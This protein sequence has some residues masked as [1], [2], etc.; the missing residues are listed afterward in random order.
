M[1]R[2]VSVFGVAIREHNDRYGL[3]RR[4]PRHGG[5]IDF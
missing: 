1:I 5:V 4:V 3:K 2:H